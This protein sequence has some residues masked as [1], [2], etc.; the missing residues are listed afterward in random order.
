MVE[1]L[2]RA[3]HAAHRLG[4]VHRELKPANVLLTADGTPKIAD[5]GLAK[6]LDADAG[7]TQ[8]GAIMG[9]PSYMAPEQAAGRIKDV[10]PAADVWALGCILYELLTGDILFPGACSN[11]RPLMKVRTAQ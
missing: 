6:Q 5:F 11:L 8:T 7:Q 4:I 1:T 10:G 2:A 9:T 3:M